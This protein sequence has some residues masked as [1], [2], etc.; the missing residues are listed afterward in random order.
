MGIDVSLGMT[1]GPCFVFDIDG[2]WVD[3]HNTL[4][5]QQSLPAAVRTAD[6]GLK[7]PFCL[8]GCCCYDRMKMYTSLM[9][10]LV[11]RHRWRK[12]DDAFV[13]RFQWK[14]PPWRYARGKISEQRSKSMYCALFNVTW[15]NDDDSVDTTVTPHA[16]VFLC[17][18]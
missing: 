1:F 12:S 11:R 2:V 15:C 14:T 9:E 3:S 18:L 7:T 17:V 13:K 6:V 10:S 5:S 8:R 16:I 4:P